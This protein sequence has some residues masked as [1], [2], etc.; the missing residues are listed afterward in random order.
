SVNNLAFLYSSQGRYEEAE[1]LQQKS[2]E[3][4]RQVLGENHPSFAISLGNLAS[5]YVQ[6][7][8]F[9]EAESFLHQALQIFQQVVGPEHPYTKETFN[10]LINLIATAIQTNQADTLSDHP[11][12]QD[13][14]PKIRTALER[15]T[16]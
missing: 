16:E 14:I 11:I 5:L 2:L 13:L 12:T 10:R 8:D 6:K 3:I 1:V 7:G 15:Q 9:S 4:H